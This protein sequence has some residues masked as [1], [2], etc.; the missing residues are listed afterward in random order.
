[1]P[2]D[3]TL[4]TVLS[5]V[6]TWFFNSDGS[7][8]SK[9]FQFYAVFGEIWQSRMFAPPTSGK[10]WICHCSYMYFMLVQLK[11][12]CN[13]VSDNLCVKFHTEEACGTICSSNS[14]EKEIR[15]G[16]TVRTSSPTH[17]RGRPSFAVGK[18][19]DILLQ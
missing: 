15:S 2:F 1:M 7:K 14:G 11:C 10:S 9:F 19:R 3:S 12:S 5:Y 6:V 13:T 8:G 17:L 4:N 16:V 18:S